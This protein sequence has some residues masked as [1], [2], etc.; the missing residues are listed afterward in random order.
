MTAPES[1]PAPMYAPQ[2]PPRKKRS[3]LK[4]I[5]I[6]VAAVVALI[7]IAVVALVLLVSGATKDAQK[8]SDPFVAAVQNGDSAKAYSLTGPR[9]RAATTPAQLDQLVKQ[10]STL[11]SKDPVSPSGKAINASTNSGK[12]AVFT[13]K[14]KG[15]KGGSVYFKTELHKES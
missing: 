10:L 12:V 4:I 6:I 15:V 7:V 1:A 11:V 8:V 14:L 3:A 2:S 13:Y 5:L 9:F